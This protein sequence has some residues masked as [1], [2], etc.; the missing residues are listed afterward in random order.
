MF[1]MSS[2]ASEAEL[3]RVELSTIQCQQR[4]WKMPAVLISFLTFLHLFAHGP[5]RFIVVSY[6]LLLF[7]LSTS[8]EHEG[9]EELAIGNAVRIC[10][11]F[12]RKDVASNFIEAVANRNDDGGS[13]VSWTVGEGVVGDAEVRHVVHAD[14]RETSEDARA[15]QCRPVKTLGPCRKLGG[16]EGDNQ[17][18]DGKYDREYGET[19]VVYELD[20]RLIL[21]KSNWF[22]ATDGTWI[23]SFQCAAVGPAV[24]M[25]TP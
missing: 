17:A 14:D 5:G 10:D 12:S 15:S 11:D 13:K 4:G 7:I 22:G 3:H 2:H 6:T 8:I 16:G 19:G 9:L 20:L 25:G 23:T 18:G 24:G 21:A 1:R